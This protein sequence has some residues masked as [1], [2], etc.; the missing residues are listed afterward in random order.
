MEKD[1]VMRRLRK[2]PLP[3]LGKHQ[4]LVWMRKNKK[5]GQILTLGG[6]YTKQYRDDI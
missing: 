6:P 2:V 5:E 4:S 3:S 1:V